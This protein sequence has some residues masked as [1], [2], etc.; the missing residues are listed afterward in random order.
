MLSDED[1]KVVKAYGVWKGKSMY[2]KKYMGIERT[3]FLIDEK[4]KISHIFP[5]VK[6]EGQTEEVIQAL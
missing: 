6:V 5:K 3:T 2:R 4:G 1:K